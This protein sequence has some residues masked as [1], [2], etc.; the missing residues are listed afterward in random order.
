[1]TVVPKA[2]PV[3]PDVLRPVPFR[4]RKVRKELSD[5]F[6]LELEAVEGPRSFPFAPGQF[7][8]LY[9][10]GV[11][12]VPISI[13]G[14]TDNPEVLT[15]TIRGVGPVTDAMRGLE[16]GDVVG[17]RG[18][19]GTPWPVADCVGSDLVFVAGGVGIAPLR[20][21]I[22]EAFRRRDDFGRVVVYYG[23]RTQD[24]ILF[25]KE[26]EDWR[27]RL[28]IDV[29]V[30]VDRA[31]RHW[32][33]N[34]GVVTKLIQRGGFDPLHTRAMV[35]GPEV[36]MRF[37]AQTLQERGVDS[38]SIFVSLERNMKCAVGWCGHCQFGTQFVC[39]DGPVYRFDKV[40]DM[41]SIREL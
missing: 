10:F 40:A 26:L 34:V 4:I 8:M 23:A 16:K 22:L 24:D 33:G 38:D 39:K 30:T 32:H 12:E 35:C 2:E 41:M 15:H 1:M 19:F 28:D 20:P 14:P 25:R 9:V 31:T 5:T 21:A 29:Q 37:S 36:M 13:S 3:A 7:N 11:G 18:P 27:S 6:T 17:V